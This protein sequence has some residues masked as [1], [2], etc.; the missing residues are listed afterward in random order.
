MTLSADENKMAK[1]LIMSSIPRSVAFTLVYAKGK[2]EVTSV[3]IERETG[4]RQPEVSIAMQWLRRKGWINKRNMKKEG[5]GR[6]VHG[7]RL[8]KD[9]DEILEE[10]IQDL[11]QKIEEVNVNIKELRQFKTDFALSH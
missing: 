3:E 6:P 8:S 9:F 7:Y 5:K 1:I 2:D 4:L 10:I 11:E